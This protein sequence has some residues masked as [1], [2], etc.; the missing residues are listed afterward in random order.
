[1]RV[2][3]KRKR[4]TS[5]LDCSLDNRD[6]TWR[7][8]RGRRGLEGKRVSQTRSWNHRQNVYYVLSKTVE[9]LLASF[10]TS[11]QMAYS[12]PGTVPSGY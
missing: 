6:G 3:I 9:L 1:M 2:Q 4:G 8:Q 10:L 12:V 5:A 7:D 11:S